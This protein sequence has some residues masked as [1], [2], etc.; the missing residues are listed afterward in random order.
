MGSIARIR[1]YAGVACFFLSTP[2]HAQETP[3]VAA[4]SRSRC[5]TEHER[6]QDARL[7]GQLL[8]ARAALRECSSA[9]CP[10]LVSRD[11][12]SWLAEVERQ[13]PS[14]IFAAAQDGQDI[15]TL[16]VKEGERVLADSITG[17]PLALDPGP[18]HFVAELPGFP[19]QEATYVLQAGDKARVVRFEFVSPLPPLPITAPATPAPRRADTALARPIPT[20]SYV[21]AG[22]ALVSA[23]TGSVL[24]TAA[25][26]K[27]KDT[28]TGCA[29]L[30]SDRDVQGMRN[31][32]LGS[33]IAF[34]LAL[35]ATGGAAYTY[36]TRP[37]V[38]SSSSPELHLTWLGAGLAA[39][40]HV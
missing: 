40:G 29:P 31:L 35:L 3:D 18:H 24:G 4:P 14:V 5:L 37:S 21:L 7:G 32:A 19:L 10:T 16:R 15:V 27:R 36:A 9:A 30:C 17:T 39:E 6:A 38:T 28:E 20:I 22:A 33:D 1:A 12:V 34:A 11:C 26:S 13:M 2:A 23:V 25:L 8:D